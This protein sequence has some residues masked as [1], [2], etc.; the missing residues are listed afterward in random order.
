MIYQLSISDII[1]KQRKFFQSGT[2]KDF[3]F[4]LAQ[5]KIL[6][7]AIIQH[8]TDITHALLADLNRAEVETYGTEIL[9][10]LSEI[11]YA[12]KNLKQWMQPQKLATS[13][14]QF[15]ASA[16]IYPEPL[17]V[18]L[19]IG[20]W[21]YPFQLTLSPLVGAIAAGNC[22]IIKPSELAS[23]CS[24]VTA[25]IISKSF[26]SEYISVV[27]GGVETS[28]LLLAEKFD[29][30]FFTGGTAIG[31]IVMEAA[32]KH[33]TP[34]TLELGGKS[35]CIVDADTNIECTA[36]R[37]VW[38]KF[39]NAGQ[40]CVAPD[41]LLVNK[42]IK[43]QLLTAIQKSIK[44]FY[45]DNPAKSLDYGRIIN[46]KHFDRLVNFLQD[47][48]ICIGGESNKNECYIAP[49][50]IDNI[51]LTSAVMQSEIFG[52]ILPI[53]EYSDI[54]EAISIINSQPKP[55][56]VY[57]FSQNKK[58]QHR[59]LQNTSSGGVCINDTVMQAAASGLPFGGVGDSGIGRY[60][61]K[62]SFETFS[63]YK[64]VLQ[65][66]FLFNIKLRYAPYKGKLQWLKRIVGSNI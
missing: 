24:R 16:R 49:T 42:N 59:I 52:P 44:E 60:H 26:A 36:Q 18:V 43:P 65:R 38:G 5:I 34:V 3:A 23:N 48:N 56:A 58:L 32:A 41:Y 46:H 8:Q 22:A 20:A 14:Q 28:Q 19:I 51:S 11:D 29:H 31:K 37:I 2:T 27:E 33:L 12:I 53:I 6:K 63:H 57:L 35:P 50:V 7:Q 54:N 13:I 17:G 25:E 15:P 40:T 45:G 4:R 1:C 9:L 10:I 39:L 55:L 21:N 62:T 30:I 64:T 66:S 47:G 61:G